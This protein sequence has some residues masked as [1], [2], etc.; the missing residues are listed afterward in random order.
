MYISGGRKTISTRN[1]VQ[2]EQIEAIEKSGRLSIKDE[3][4]GGMRKSPL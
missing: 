3:K 4:M 1:E 2:L